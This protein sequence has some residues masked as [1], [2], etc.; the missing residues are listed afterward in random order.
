MILFSQPVPK[1]SL[2][3]KSVCGSFYIVKVE[4]DGGDTTIKDRLWLQ[5][6]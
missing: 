2:P 4:K 1:F 6:F 5:D 3:T